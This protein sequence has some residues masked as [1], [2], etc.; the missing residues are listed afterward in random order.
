M[1]RLSLEEHKRLFEIE[2][3]INKCKKTYAQAKKDIN[4]AQSDEQV[5]RILAYMCYLTDKVDKLKL[6]AYYER[7]RL[8]KIEQ[9]SC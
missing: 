4:D 5:N 9:R 1:K 8:Q 6:Q 2:L 7:R 3:E